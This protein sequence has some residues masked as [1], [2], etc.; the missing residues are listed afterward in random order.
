MQVDRHLYILPLHCLFLAL[1]LHRPVDTAERFEYPTAAV[2]LNDARS[3][4]TE[5][6]NT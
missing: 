1:L 4:R 5:V 3:A 6:A 2:L